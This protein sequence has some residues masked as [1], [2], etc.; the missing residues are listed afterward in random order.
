[1][2]PILGIWA[3]QNYTRITGSYD[4]IQTVN[5][6]SNT[7]S[8]SFSS[9]PSTYKHLQIRSISAGDQNV[10]VR[11]RFNG[12]TGSNYAWHEIAAGAGYGASVYAYNGTSQTSIQLL[13][14]QLGNSTNFNTNITDILDYTSTNK[15]KTTRTLTGVRGG[16]G[17]FI[18]FVSGL[19][20]NT[21]AVTSMTLYPFTGN[22]VANTTFALY[23]IKG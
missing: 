21:S 23:G 13:D 19:W 7:A 8:I 6:T 11:C 14:Q 15:N 10:G 16:S 5:V 18:Y 17:G 12:D 1:M 2:S 9:I 4:S 22:F 20:I 3:S